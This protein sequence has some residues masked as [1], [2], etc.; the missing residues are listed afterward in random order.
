MMNS[1]SPGLRVRGFPF[2]LVRGPGEIPVGLPGELF[3]FEHCNTSVGAFPRDNPPNAHLVPPPAVWPD[4]PPAVRSP[5]PQPHAVSRIIGW[6]TE[7]AEPGTPGS[8]QELVAIVPDGNRAHSHQPLMEAD[9]RECGGFAPPGGI[10][11]RDDFALAEVIGDRLGRP[12][13]VAIHR[14]VRGLA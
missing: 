9:G 14:P 2:R 1:A 3:I 8:A 13:R 11:Q 7:N 4:R 5:L 12:L 6:G 10:P